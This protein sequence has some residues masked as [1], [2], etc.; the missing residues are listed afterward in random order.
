MLP[1]DVVQKIEAAKADVAQMR[2]RNESLRKSLAEKVPE[3]EAVPEETW[4]D[5]SVVR[6]VERLERAAERVKRISSQPVAPMLV[7]SAVAK[8]GR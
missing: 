3:Q 5:P 1:K 2:E 8:V 6:E 4:D 7:N